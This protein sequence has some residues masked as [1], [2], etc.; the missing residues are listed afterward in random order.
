VINAWGFLSHEL[1]DRLGLPGGGD[2]PVA[3][4]H[5]DLRPSPKLLHRSQVHPILD[6]SCGERVAEGMG[7]D[8][9]EARPSAGR[10]EATTDVCIWFSAGLDEHKPQIPLLLCRQFKYCGTFPCEIGNSFEIE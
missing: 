8:I 6:Q 1:L 4:Q 9:L 3:G 2:V 10:V 7:R 5:L